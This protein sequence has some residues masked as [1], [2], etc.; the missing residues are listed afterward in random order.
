MAITDYT[1]PASVRAIIG[2]SDDEIDDITIE[3]SIYSNLLDEAFYDLSPT[4]EA[5]YATTKASIPLNANQ[6]RFVRLIE[7]WAGY[8]V[9]GFLMTSME[10]FA[11]QIIKSDK[12]E[13]A[14]VSNPYVNVETNIKQITRSLANRILNLYPVLFPTHLVPDP[15]KYIN[16]VATSAPVDPVTG[17]ATF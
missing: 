17:D 10:M 8:T 7:T 12:D 2:V 11:P 3:N 1:T 14:R 5:D 16:V 15:V 6:V 13:V 9:A 4:M